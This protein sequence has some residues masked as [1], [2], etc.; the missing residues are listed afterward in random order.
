M[1]RPPVAPLIAPPSVSPL[2]LLTV[3]VGVALPRAI[4]GLR[5]TGPAA[6]TTVIAAAPPMASEL[7]SAF[8]ATVAES[9]TVKVAIDMFAPSTMLPWFDAPLA[10]SVTLAAGPGIRLVA[11]PAGVVTQLP[12]AAPSDTAQALPP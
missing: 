12:A 6:A 8:K 9:A 11:P 4:F 2:L 7:P 3:I 5:V 10:E 1:V